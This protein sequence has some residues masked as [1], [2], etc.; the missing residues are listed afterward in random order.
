MSYVTTYRRPPIFQADLVLGRS[1]CKVSSGENEAVV[2][3]QHELHE[4]F[5]Y[6]LVIVKC[7]PFSKV[8]QKMSS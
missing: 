5:W 6:Y 8:F 4:G 3:V 1:E 7:T 2:C